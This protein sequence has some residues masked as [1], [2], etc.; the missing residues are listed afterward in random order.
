MAAGPRYADC[1]INASS[2]EGTVKLNINV[3]P[4]GKKISKSSF[5]TVSPHY[6]FLVMTIISLLFLLFFGQS[7]SQIHCP[8]THMLKQYPMRESVP[9][10]KKKSVPFLGM[11]YLINKL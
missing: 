11:V 8:H 7:Q 2:R 9:F 1:I 4:F 5:T 6:S 10:K 3:S